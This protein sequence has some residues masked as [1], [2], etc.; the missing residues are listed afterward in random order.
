MNFTREPTIETIIT[1]K[2]GGKL[3]VRCSKREAP[4]EF[5]VDA[6]EVVSFGR[7]IFY[8]CMERPKPFLVPVSDYDIIEVKETRMMLKSA[9]IERS[10]KIGGGKVA[11]RPEVEAVE[12]KEAP[13]EKGE[14]RSE[15][16]R[17][18]RRSKRRPRLEERGSEEV[19]GKQ[20]EVLRAQ[21]QEETA[22]LQSAPQGVAME[23]KEEKKR[24]ARLLPP[25][26]TLIAHTMS[27]YREAPAAEPLPSVEEAEKEEDAKKKSSK[28]KAA[29]EKEIEEQP[30]E[31]TPPEEGEKQG[32]SSF[33]GFFS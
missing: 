26:P 9:P 3:L 23:G 7:S 24:F 8:R 21:E 32:P 16:K 1:P 22:E 27:K 2:E 18:R 11:P 12:G 13:Q 10:I 29:R 25:P 6:V 31:P 17:D 14:G 20:E 15:K 28:S 33:W 5:L 30:V 19:A 4:E